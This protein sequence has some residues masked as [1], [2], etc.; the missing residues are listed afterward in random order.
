MKQLFLIFGI[1][2]I[3]LSA[4]GIQSNALHVNKKNIDKQ[5]VEKKMTDDL[6]KVKKHK[7]QRFFKR[8]KKG[9]KRIFKKIR[10]EVEM[11]I[12]IILA[13]FIPPLCVF[14]VVGATTHFWLN[15]IFTLFFWFPGII[16]ALFVLFTM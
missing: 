16:H 5:I 15:I 14:M 4:M 11:I 7:S 3:S 13:I 9:V 10:D 6:Q 12:M 8:I 2:I 1:L